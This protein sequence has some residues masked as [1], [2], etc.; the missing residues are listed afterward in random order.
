MHIEIISFQAF[1]IAECAKLYCETYSAEP[2]NE[3]WDSEQPIIDFLSAHF[4]N[5]YF[6]GFVVKAENKIIAASIGFKKPW[7]QGME[8][9]IDEFFI[10]PAYQRLHIGSR[11]MQYI[12]QQCQTLKLNAVILNTE[13]GYPS[14]LFYKKNHFLEHQGLMI[15]SKMLS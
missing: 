10:H 7:N 15:L 14:E 3:H 8:Y 2:W 6:L 1:H 4:A 9:Y 12:E 5:N 11:L 13:R